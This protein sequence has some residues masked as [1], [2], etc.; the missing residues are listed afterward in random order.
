[1]FGNYIMFHNSIIIFFI[2]CRDGIIRV[3]R[4]SLFDVNTPKYYNFLLCLAIESAYAYEISPIVCS[5]VLCRQDFNFMLPQGSL[6]FTETNGVFHAYELVI[7][8]ILAV[9]VS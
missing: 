2:G 6:S 1:M 9:S 7:I 3:S 8:L 5:S 4:L